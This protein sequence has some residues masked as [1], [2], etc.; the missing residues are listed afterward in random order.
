MESRATYLIL[1]SAGNVAGTGG[2]V[3]SEAKALSAGTDT[4]SASPAA[5]P[6]LRRY[7]IISSLVFR[8]LLL[9]VSC[10]DGRL[11]WICLP[12]IRRRTRFSDGLFQRGFFGAQFLDRA[13]ASPSGTGP[14]PRLDGG[15]RQP[16][17]GC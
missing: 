17:L 10:L 16:L 6:M 4:L 11:R 1:P 8:R 2:T 15:F 5:M 9:L 12:W 3:G 7:L 14:F 13:H